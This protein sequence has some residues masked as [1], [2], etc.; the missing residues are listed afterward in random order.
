MPEGSLP[1]PTSLGARSVAPQRYTP[2][3]IRRARELIGR[4]MGIRRAAKFY[5]A[6][7]P[8]LDTAVAEF[9]AVVSL[10]LNERAE[11]ELGFVQGE[12]LLGEQLLTEESVSYAQLTSELTE[13]GVGSITISPG[14]TAGELARAMKILGL[15]APALAAAGGLAAVV[16]QNEF[17][18]LSIGSMRTV[19]RERNDHFTMPASA[20][21]AYRSAIA[22][23]RDLEEVVSGD[24]EADPFKIDAAVRALIEN[25]MSNRH[26]MLQLAGV[27]DHDE[28]TYQHS[29]NVAALSLS[30]GSMISTERVFM[31]NLGVGAL[32]H[33]VGKLS[34]EKAIIN[35]AGSLTPEEWEKMRRHPVDGAEIVSAIPGVDKAAVVAVVEHH[36]R[37]DN[38]GYPSRTPARRQHLVSRIVAVADSY[39]AMTSRRSYSAARLPDEAMSLMVQNAGTSLDPVLVRLFVRLMGVY[40]PRSLVRLAGGEIAIVIQANA[41]SPS[42][43]VVRIVAAPS[44][45][46]ITATDVDLSTTLELSVQACLDPRTVDIDVDA[47]VN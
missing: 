46:L 36:M 20:R 24:A 40:P 5:P 44:G 43:P 42:R 25:V 23:I 15:D 8:A 32:L 4:L 18:H 22:L 17:T 39:D 34:V 11:V 45:D 14:V 37:F 41:E 6:G 1:R 26:A 30:L 19:E 29:A 13:L 7:H 31:G 10:Y 27:R 38:A 28:Y 47:Y 35:K 33:D 12:I 9:E 21:A 16:A 3:Q 2:E